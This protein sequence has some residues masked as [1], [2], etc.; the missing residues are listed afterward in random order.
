MKKTVL[1]LLALG[2]MATVMGSVSAADI[3]SIS[4]KKAPAN[5]KIDAVFDD[6]WKNATLMTVGEKDPITAAFGK[7]WNNVAEDCKVWVMWD[8]SYFYFFADKIDGFVTAPITDTGAGAPW[9]DDAIGMFMRYPD[10]SGFKIPISVP[11][12]D[13]EMIMGYAPVGPG[14]AAVNPDMGVAKFAATKTGYNMEAKLKWAE[15]GDWTPKVGDV[16]NFTPLVM[17]RDDNDLWGQTMWVGDG[18]NPDLYATT[19]FVD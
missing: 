15:I 5:V 16:V 7:V 17:D 14:G 6:Q 10:G 9:L 13:G 19:T 1:S 3:P 4:I 12:E 2:L 8:S 11:T 18:D